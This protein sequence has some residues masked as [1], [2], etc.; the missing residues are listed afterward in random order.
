LH[1]YAIHLVC[2]LACDFGCCSVLATRGQASCYLPI[3]VWKLIKVNLQG[4]SQ[5]SRL[6]KPVLWLALIFQCKYTNYS[7]MLYLHQ[8]KSIL[9]TTE[10]HIFPDLERDCKQKAYC[11]CHSHAI[12]NTAHSFSIC[13]IWLLFCLPVIEL[14]M[15]DRTKFLDA[16]ITLLSWAP[17]TS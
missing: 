11:F 16:L 5:L 15:E 13:I 8:R 1:D 17:E 10:N 9:T 2:V 7:D 12:Q 4:S 14:K 6:L 3:T